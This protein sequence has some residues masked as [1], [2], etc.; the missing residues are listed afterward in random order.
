MKHNVDVFV[1]IDGVNNKYELFFQHCLGVSEI[2][3]GVK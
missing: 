1:I 3:A 2:L